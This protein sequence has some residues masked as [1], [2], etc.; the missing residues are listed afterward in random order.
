MMSGRAWVIVLGAVTIFAAGFWL[1]PQNRELMSGLSTPTVT[2]DG[3]LVG[4]RW[5]YRTRSGEEDSTFVVG[6]IEQSPSGQRIV[7]VRVEGVQ[8]EISPLPKTYIPHVPMDEGVLLNSR[9][10]RRETGIDAGGEFAIWYVDW[11]DADAGAFVI[12]LSEVID[13]IER[14]LERSEPAEPRAHHLTFDS[15]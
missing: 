5:S 1:Q 15:A 13:V 7:H 6:R 2:P 10:E 3:F 9:L 12:P 11:R 8:L 4:E 14:A